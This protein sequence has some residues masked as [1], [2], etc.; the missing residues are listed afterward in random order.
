MPPLRTTALKE[1]T[2]TP[3][4]CLWTCAPI[5][6]EGPVRVVLDAPPLNCFLVRQARHSLHRRRKRCGAQTE[7]SAQRVESFNSCPLPQ[8]GVW[9]LA[10]RSLAKTHVDQRQRAAGSS[11]VNSRA[12]GQAR[13]TPHEVP[14]IFIQGVLDRKKQQMRACSDF[15]QVHLKRIDTLNLSRAVREPR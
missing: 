14:R 12:E 3:T 4:C 9:L 1:R 7:S 2:A 15:M 10:L 13:T 5:T 8:G 11:N 6:D